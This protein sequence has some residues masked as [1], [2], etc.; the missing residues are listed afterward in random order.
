MSIIEHFNSPD[1]EQSQHLLF[2]SSLLIARKMLLLS[3]S[4]DSSNWLE[5]KAFDNESFLLL[6]ITDIHLYDRKTTDNALMFKE[7]L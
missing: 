7:N 5:D 2:P 1:M 6:L 4:T 3:S